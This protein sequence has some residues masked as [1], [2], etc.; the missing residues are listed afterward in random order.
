MFRLK[1]RKFVELIRRYSDLQNLPVQR[2]SKNSNGHADVVDGEVFEQDMDMDENVSEEARWGDSMDTDSQVSGMKS[3]QLLQEA[4]EYG[5]VLMQEY[6]EESNEYKKRLEE[7]FSLIAYHDAKN[8]I[9]GHLLDPKGRVA[10]AEE[11]NSAILGEFLIPK[12]CYQT[13]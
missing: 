10:V 7:V 12:R 11:L 5:Q 4:M 2:S 9:H 3:E 8:S 1:C 6:R 13:R